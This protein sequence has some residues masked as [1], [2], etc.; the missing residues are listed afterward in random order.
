MNGRDEAEP[1]EVVSRNER[2]GSVET[3]SKLIG[4]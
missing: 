1:A 2:A 4:F 3:K